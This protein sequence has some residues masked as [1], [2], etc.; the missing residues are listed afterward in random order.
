MSHRAGRADGNA[1]LDERPFRPEVWEQPRSNVPVI[2]TGWV[3]DGCGMNTGWVRDEH[4][5]GAGWIR[6]GC[7]MDARW[8]RDGCGRNVRW[9]RD[10]HGMGAARERHGYGMGAAWERDGIRTG[11]ARDRNGLGIGTRSAQYTG[12][13]PGRFAPERC[14]A[15]HHAGDAREDERDTAPKY[16]REEMRQTVHARRQPATTE[17]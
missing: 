5:I 4:E 3:R 13:T 1:E 17:T 11:S 9:I 8:M 15:P 16:S 6:D 2:G 14:D 12:N 7:G 10:G